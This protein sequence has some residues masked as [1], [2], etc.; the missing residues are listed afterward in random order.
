MGVERVAISVSQLCELI[1][2]DPR[3][4]VGVERDKGTREG[5]SANRSRLWIVL[6]PKPEARCRS[7]IGRFRRQPT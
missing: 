1:G 3:R 7:V 4:F 2:V 5:Q 6:E